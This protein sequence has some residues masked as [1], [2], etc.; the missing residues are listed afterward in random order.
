MKGK[1]GIMKGRKTGIMLLLLLVVLLGIGGVYEM[2][3]GMEIPGLSHVAKLVKKPEPIN[4]DPEKILSLP[5]EYKEEAKHQGT[6]KTLTYD[7]TMYEGSGSTVEKKAVV[8]LPYDYDES[9]KYDVFYLMHGYGGG[10]HTFLGS[11]SNPRAFKNMLDHMIEDH[12]IEPFIVVTPTYTEEYTDYYT[13]LDEMGTEVVSTL[14]PLVEEKYSTY[15]D[16]TDEEDLMASRDHRAI[17]GFSMGGCSTWRALRSYKDYFEYYLPVSMPMYYSDYGYQS[18]ESTYSAQEIYYGVEEAEDTE[19]PFYVFAAS[20]TEDFMCEATEMQVEDL[21]DYEG[22][23]YTDTSFQDG[24]VMFHAWKGRKH[25]YKY[26]L[27][28]FYN[29]LIRSFRDSVEDPA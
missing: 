29:G 17:G 4:K 1:V 12:K 21:C 27:P 3:Q 22:F 23:T 25:S 8:Y 13:K 20:G 5:A 6:L 2:M 16:S 24:N 18:G 26:S 9:K 11:K 10:C 19:S 28:Y 7:Y 15:A 14:M